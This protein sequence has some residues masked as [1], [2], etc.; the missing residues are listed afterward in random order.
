MRERSSDP[1]QFR[2]LHQLLICY[3]LFKYC[4]GTSIYAFAQSF[5]V[6]SALD[7]IISFPFGFNSKNVT[8]FLCTAS[9]SDLMG[10]PC[11]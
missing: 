3:M 1:S 2:I 7:V 5:T 11:C 10:L 4:I 6:P 9:G 8:A